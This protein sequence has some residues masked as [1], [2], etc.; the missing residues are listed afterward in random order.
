MEEIERGLLV[1]ANDE[2]ENNT[3]AVIDGGISPF[4]G[5]QQGMA[6][7]IKIYFL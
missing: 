5:N 7:Y 6:K 2:I 1:Y 3:Q 4:L